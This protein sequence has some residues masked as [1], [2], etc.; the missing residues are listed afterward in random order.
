M[1]TCDHVC[2]VCVCVCVSHPGSKG[3]PRAHLST[4]TAALS[5]F[6]R[7]RGAVDHHHSLPN[8]DS[9]GS[10]VKQCGTPHCVPASLELLHTLSTPL[11]CFHGP[12]MILPLNLSLHLVHRS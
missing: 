6:H 5:F 8:E 10:V 4:V 12:C 1:I 3:L 2:H 11:V 7:S 9:D